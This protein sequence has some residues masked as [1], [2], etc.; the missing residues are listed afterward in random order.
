M[1]APGGRPAANRVR[2][3]LVIRCVRL[4]FGKGACYRFSLPEASGEPPEGPTDLADNHTPPFS[5]M[6]AK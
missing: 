2:V 6:H 4:G 5:A 3:A 1:T